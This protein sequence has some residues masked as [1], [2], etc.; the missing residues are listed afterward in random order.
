MKY[1]VIKIVNGNNE[2]VSEG[3]EDIS[4][5]KVSFHNTCK[6]IYNDIANVDTMAVMILD[7]MGNI[8]EKD[9][10]DASMYVTPES[11]AESE[12]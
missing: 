6:V 8:V 10:Y 1:A 4:K 5:A 12:E 7:N 2:V 11:V 3:W 9:S